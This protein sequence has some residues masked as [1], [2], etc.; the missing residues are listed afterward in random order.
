MVG[1]PPT[2]IPLPCNF[3]LVHCCNKA[4]L[5]YNSPSIHFSSSQALQYV[6]CFLLGICWDKLLKSSREAGF[7]CSAIH[8]QIYVHTCF[9]RSK[10]I[11]D[12]VLS[13]CPKFLCHR[14]ETE[15]QGAP[16]LEIHSSYED[17]SKWLVIDVISIEWQM[18]AFAPI[19]LRG[20]TNVRINSLT[21]S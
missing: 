9:G 18:N 8:R 7:L 2:E 13:L 21:W 11:A 3:Q 20:V 10:V 5:S 1:G 16:T 12:K 19:F 15:D 4:P 14:G 6:R 17:W